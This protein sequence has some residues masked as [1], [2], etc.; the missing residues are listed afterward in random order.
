MKGINVSCTYFCI[1]F[2]LPL[3]LF[4][5]LHL[6]FFSVHG[7]LCSFLCATFHNPLYCCLCPNRAWGC[8]QCFIGTQ[9]S[10]G[11]SVC[12]L[13]PT[14]YKTVTE[15]DWQQSQWEQNLARRRLSVNHCRGITELTPSAPYIV[16]NRLN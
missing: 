9:R 7:T 13:S 14:L 6:F 10:R 11:I 5:F 15:V 16:G 2:S 3:P 8:G 12:F 4:D 1:L